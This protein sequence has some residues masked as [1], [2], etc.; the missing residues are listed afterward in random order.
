[1]ISDELFEKIAEVIVEKNL[2]VKQQVTQ[3]ISA[4]LLKST[5]RF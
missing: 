2:L 5:K 1:M 4:E 3:V